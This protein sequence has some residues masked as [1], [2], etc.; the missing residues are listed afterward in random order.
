MGNICFCCTPKD[1]QGDIIALYYFDPITFVYC[2]GKWQFKK[3]YVKQGF[4]WEDWASEFE[5]RY[6][7]QAAE[8]INHKVPKSCTFFCGGCPRLK[9]CEA[10][11]NLHWTNE[12]NEWLKPKGFK[13]RC[14]YQVSY[15]GQ[16]AQERF[17]VTIYKLDEETM[18]EIKD[19]SEPS[20]TDPIKNQPVFN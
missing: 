6:L 17:A 20:K 11:L 16:S 4:G 9:T 5:S 10:Q 2:C 12:V 8:E 15:N 7:T 3:P 14:W 13:A 18:A 1:P 19:G